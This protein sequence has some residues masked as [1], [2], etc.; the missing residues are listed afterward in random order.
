[1]V[2][3][4]PS[5]A[6]AYCA[7]YLAYLDEGDFENA[8]SCINEAIR[9]NSGQ[10]A[11]YVSRGTLYSAMGDLDNAI[12]DYDKAIQLN[13][14]YPN[15][16]FSRCLAYILKKEWKKAK[17]DLTEARDMGMDIIAKFQSAFE[18]VTNFE[19]ISGIKLPE[20]IAEMLTPPQP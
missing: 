18:S 3:L 16:Y 10:P 20:D 15:T 7:L 11:F 6:A 9:L 5:D 14:N 4:D 8:F 13:S 12:K 1:M 2:K 17:T 19:R